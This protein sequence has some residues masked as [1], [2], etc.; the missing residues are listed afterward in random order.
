MTVVMAYTS[1]L[2]MA[3]GIRVYRQQHQPHVLNAPYHKVSEPSSHQRTS[4]A[5]L[6]Q[7]HEAFDSVCHVA[8]TDADHVPF[9]VLLGII[10]RDLWSGPLLCALCGAAAG[11]RFIQGWLRPRFLTF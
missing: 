8:C 7:M 4:A 9:C 6:G 3:S 2:F 10:D 1:T 5:V 11:T